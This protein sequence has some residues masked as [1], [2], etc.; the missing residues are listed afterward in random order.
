MHPTDHRRDHLDAISVVV[1][2]CEGSVCVDNLDATDMSL[3]FVVQN[4]RNT[5]PSQQT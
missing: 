1:L 5:N 2:G 3:W 4:L